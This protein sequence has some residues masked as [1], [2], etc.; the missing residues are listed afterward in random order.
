M[1]I[2]LQAKLMELREEIDDIDSKILQL[3]AKRSGIVEEVGQIKKDSGVSG[4]FIRS[5]REAK[6]MKMLLAEGAGSFP[7]QALFAIWRIIITASLDME[8]GLKIVTKKT[9]D[10]DE[11]KKII[12]YFGTFISYEFYDDE[13]K[14]ISNVDDKTVGILSLYQSDWWE[15][16]ENKDDLKIFAKLGND[17]Y[18]FAKLK[19]EE[20]GKDITLMIADEELAKGKKIANRGSKEL[21]E[22]EGYFDEYRGAKVIGSYA[23]S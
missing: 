22:V 13:D 2:M 14:V 9:S 1:N 12:E 5:G 21:I 23:E 18:A 10:F 16:L 8:G 4:N 7:K 20:T 19:P 6:M 17:L 11:I 15:E 3:L